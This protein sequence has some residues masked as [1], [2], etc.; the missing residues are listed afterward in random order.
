M[1]FI[2]H[3]LDNVLN[4]AD[5][6]LYFIITIGILVFVHEF[7][8]FAAAKLSKMRVD[9]FAIGFGQRLFGWNKL[10]G[11]TFGNLPK[12]F[13]GQG[14]TDYRLSLLPLGGYVKIAGMVDESFDTKFANTEPKPYEFRAKK[15]LPKLFVITA[16]V[17]MNLTLTIMIFWGINFFHGKEVPKSVT[18]AKIDHGSVGEKAGFQTYDKILSVNGVAVNDWNE[19]YENIV[20]NNQ[21]RDVSVKVE[22]NGTEK[23]ISLS[24]KFIT[25]NSQKG[26][27]LFPYP[28]TQP[29]IKE[30]MK[31]SPAEDAKMKAGDTILSINEININDGEQINEIVTSNKETN[32]PVVLLRGKDT[33]RTSVKPGE[34]GMIG[35]SHSVAYTGEIEYRTYSFFGSAS[36]A[37]ADATQYTVLTFSMLKNVLTGKI[38]FKQAFGG[39]IKIAQFAVK[40]ADTGIISF[41]L[42][43]AMLSLSLAIINILP[44]PVLDGGHFVILLLEGIFK[45]ELPIKIKMVI[46]NIGFALLLLLMAFIIYNDVISL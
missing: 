12:D 4:S 3:I 31:N 16:G 22:R 25:E 9:V 10:T 33:V 2:K 36:H 44:F 1:E 13:D 26:F 39:P 23:N 14:N 35:I 7:G 27:F 45:R 20:L 8:H 41:L 40:S 42:F 28:T 6:I 43:L 19:V 5:Y 29:F 24:N 30:V 34:D 46:Q 11:F 17:L 32:L 18:V 21:S 15:T 38:A 37:F